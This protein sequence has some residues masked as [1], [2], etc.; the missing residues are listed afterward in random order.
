MPREKQTRNYHS[1]TLYLEAARA[2]ELAELSR[3]TRIPRAVL[4]REAVDLLLA[5]YGVPGA[6]DL[7]VTVPTGDG[8]R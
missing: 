6:V 4:L 7:R 1:Q 5:R 3:V 8:G 2:D